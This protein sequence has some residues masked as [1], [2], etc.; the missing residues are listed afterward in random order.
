MR[1]VL[2]PVDGARGAFAVHFGAGQTLG[3]PGRRLNIH[4][5]EGWG[6]ESSGRA[7]EI[8]LCLKGRYQPP[9]IDDEFGDF[10]RLVPRTGRCR[11]R[12]LL[13]LIIG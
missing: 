1:P 9:L 2:H 8:T 12:S 13:V 3:D 10:G 7:T 11:R 4:R 6:L 5:W